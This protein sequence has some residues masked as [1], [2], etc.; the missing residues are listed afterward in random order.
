VKEAAIRL[1]LAD[2]PRAEGESKNKYCRRI[3]AIAGVCPSYV[4]QRLEAMRC[5][6]IGAERRAKE[7]E[8]VKLNCKVMPF[9]GNIGP[10]QNF[11]GWIDFFSKVKILMEAYLLVAQ[12]RGDVYARSFIEQIRE[13]ADQAATR[14]AMSKT[15]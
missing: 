15:D 3:A 6:A 9:T 11:H 10:V 2:N 12:S 7:A 14:A 4:W 1:A 5:E 8:E 13:K